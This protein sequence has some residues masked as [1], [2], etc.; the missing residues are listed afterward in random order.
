MI[1]QIWQYQGD[2]LTLCFFLFRLK[3]Y[4]FSGGPFYISKIQDTV[5]S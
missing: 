2:L 4:V 5:L 1:P 3:I